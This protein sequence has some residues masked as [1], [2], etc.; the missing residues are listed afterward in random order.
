V[1]DED[2]MD[3]TIVMTI[4]GGKIRYRDGAIVR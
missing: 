2:I 4:L 3:T 1:A